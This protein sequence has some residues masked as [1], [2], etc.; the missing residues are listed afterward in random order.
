M[1][2]QTLVLFIIKKKLQTLR[3]PILMTV[4]I[5]LSLFVILQLLHFYLS[6][7]IKAEFS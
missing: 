2:Q 6:A 4:N 1:Q 7:Y 5:Y 3:A